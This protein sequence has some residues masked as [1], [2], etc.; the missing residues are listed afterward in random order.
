MVPT[1]DRTR[2]FISQVWVHCVV[3]VSR[4]WSF[5]VSEDCIGAR[6]P[7]MPKHVIHQCQ[8]LFVFFFSGNFYRRET[9]CTENV[10]ESGENGTRVD[11]HIPGFMKEWGRLDYCLSCRETRIS[12]LLLLKIHEA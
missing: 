2:P 12:Y 3:L 6:L 7:C 10:V 9:S 8:G 5:Q 11:N 4:I 1:S